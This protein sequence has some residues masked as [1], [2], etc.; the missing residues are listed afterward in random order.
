MA[1]SETKA[2]LEARDSRNFFQILSDIQ[3]KCA[4]IAEQLKLVL[5]WL[6]SV[7]ATLY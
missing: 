4:K 7:V 2:N 5:V 1:M 6:C 3:V